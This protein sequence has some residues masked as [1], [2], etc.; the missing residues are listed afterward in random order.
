LGTISST[1]LKTVFDACVD[2]G[3]DRLL[4][5]DLIEGGHNALNNPSRRFPNGIMIDVLNTSAKITGNETIGLK[6]GGSLRPSTFLDVGYAMTFCDTLGNV[7]RTNA[8]YQPLTQEIGRTELRINGDTAYV[9]W[10]PNYNDTER[11]RHMVDAAFAGYAN[12]GRW[13]LWRADQPILSMHFR[14]SSP[15]DMSAYE[16]TF[17]CPLHFNAE[18]DVMVL[19]AD[20][21]ST[22]LP[23]S[24][25]DLLEHLKTKLDEQMARLNEP[26]TVAT[27]VRL[28]IQ[29]QLALGG[30]GIK[31][32][33]QTLG[34][35]VRSLRRRLSDAGLTYRDVLEDARQEACDVYLRQ[36]RL[37]QTEIAQ[38]LGYNDQSAF[39]RAF[40]RWHGISP[41]HYRSTQFA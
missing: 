37:S 36:D 33:A 28:V 7:L 27:E 20:L 18:D 5:L 31:D 15:Q 12:I 8:R 17:G 21:L 29:K 39:S 9:L 19:D 41:G 11:H 24:N 3:A 23:N 10:H 32:T 13:L 2:M 22:P 14:H 6:A 34:V 30:T 25:P 1:Y 16:A 40:R 26:K 4:L 38:M 35:S